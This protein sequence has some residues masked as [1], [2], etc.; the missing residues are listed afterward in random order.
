MTKQE[1]IQEV[2]NLIDAGFK[3][4]CKRK[5]VSEYDDRTSEM[6]ILDFTKSTKK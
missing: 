4:D 3:L 5:T 2:S 6:V 1:I